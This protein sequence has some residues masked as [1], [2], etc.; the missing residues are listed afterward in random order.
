MLKKNQA[1]GRQ[2]LYIRS[3]DRFM[4]QYF[5]LLFQMM[6]VWYNE[7]HM[8]VYN[9]NDGE[10]DY[11][12]AN[13]YL[14]DEG[15]AVN[16]KAGSTPPIDKQRQEAIALQ[17]SKMGVLSPLDIYKMLHLQ[18]PQQLYDNY[19]KFKADPMSLAR[20]AM[21][22]VD[23]TK[24]Y[25]AWTVIRAGKEAEDAKDADKEFVLTL[26]KIMLTDEF[27][28]SKKS[29]QK[30]FLTYVDKAISSLELRTSLD[31]MS[32]QGVQNLETN[33]PIQP[34]QPEMPMGGS[35]IPQMGG[36][37]PMGQPP[38]PMQPPQPMGQP[39]MGAGPMAPGGPVQNG[40]PLMN[41]ANPQMPPAGNVTS[42]PTL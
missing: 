41:P 14:F 20:D 17:L 4:N 27:L 38:M 34:L 7:D 37:P 36:Q 28:D 32:Q 42:L 29:V 21:D 22:D 33:V 30:K 40:T 39:P 9:G 18:N 1:A 24:A 26:R 5:N 11:L 19:S 16:V 23:S 15:I 6:I 8:F 35:A 12:M 3:I 13:R 31:Q 2:D 10:F 25:M